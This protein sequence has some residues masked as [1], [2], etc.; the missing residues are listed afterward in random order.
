MLSLTLGVLSPLCGMTTRWFD[1]LQR[2][3]NS[4]TGT[5]PP[6]SGVVEQEISVLGALCACAA[7]VTKTM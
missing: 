6:E 1:K 2:S 4:F 5:K 7:V 3:C